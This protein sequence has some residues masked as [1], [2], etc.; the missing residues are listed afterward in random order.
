MN[1]GPSPSSPDILPKKQLHRVK[2]L[3]LSSLACPALQPPSPVL[4]PQP[5][6]Q[7]P[8]PPLA[9]LDSAVNH[10]CKGGGLINA[11][12]TEGGKNPRKGEGV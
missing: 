4:R 10:I 5:G 3:D 6:G 8:A 1:P 11:A 9:G 12:V 7:P 2:I